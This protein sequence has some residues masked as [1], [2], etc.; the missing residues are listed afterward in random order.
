MI[1]GI[2]SKNLE[3]T[4]PVL[5]QDVGG[6]IHQLDAVVDTAYDGYL[7]LPS[8][9]VAMLGLPLLRWAYAQLADGNYVNLPI[10]GAHVNWDGQ[11]RALQVDGADVQPLVGRGLLLGYELR[12]HFV[13]GGSVTVEAR[14]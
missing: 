11:L 12:V 14:P 13:V 4:I 2:V 1:T 6:R 7:T 3:V 9:V 5:I 8:A 10:H